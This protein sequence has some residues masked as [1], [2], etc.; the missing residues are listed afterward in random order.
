M[1]VAQQHRQR[2]GAG[3]LA[4]APGRAR[5]R[6]GRSRTR[7]ARRG[8]PARTGRWRRRLR[9]R[10]QARNPIGVLEH[11][12][13]AL[14]QHP[15]PA[16]GRRAWRRAREARC[17]CTRPARPR[18][19]RPRRGRRSS[20]AVCVERGKRG[21]PTG[22]VPARQRALTRDRAPAH[23]DRRWGIRPR[24]RLVRLSRSP[25]RAEKRRRARTLVAFALAGLLGAFF[26]PAGRGFASRG[27]SDLRFA[28]EPSRR[29]A[30]RGPRA[31]RRRRG[32]AGGDAAA[33]G[34]RAPSADRGLRRVAAAA[35]PG[36]G[37]ALARGAPSS[38]SGGIPSRRWRRTSRAC[39]ATRT[40][41]SETRWARA[42][43][44]ERAA[45]EL[46]REPGS[47]AA[48][49]DRALL[50]AQRRRGRRHALLSRCLGALSARTGGARGDPAPRGARARRSGA[51]CATPPRSSAAATPSSAPTATR[52]RSPPTTA[53][54]PRTRSRPRSAAARSAS[55]P[56]RSS[57]CA[58]I[59]EAAEAF[60]ALPQ[61]DEARIARARCSRA[62]ATCRA[63]RATLETIGRESRGEQAAR[64]SLLA[65][66]LLDGEGEPERARELFDAV[67][68][69]AGAGSWADEALWQLGWNAYRGGRFERGHGAL[70]A[71]RGAHPGSDRRAA[72]ALLARARRAAR[73]LAGHD[74][75][76]AALARSYPLTYYG[77]RA[78]ARSRA[79]RGRSERG[80]VPAGTRGALARGARAARILL[81]ADLREHALAELDR[82]F[83]ARAAS[84]IG[85]R[86]PSSTAMPATSIGPSA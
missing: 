51:R 55:A 38:A 25:S 84:T 73:G 10:D 34:R 71:A 67:V 33:R 69:T 77:W 9:G 31:R 1:R 49:R 72:P 61:D 70:R 2:I 28:A 24:R 43:V 32:E 13:A 40:P 85:W 12:L 59:R 15:E 58:A 16:S 23:S 42:A 83:P 7:R 37:Q 65:G 78:S 27:R 60:A 6:R 3:R 64:A 30:A 45:R 36:G 20:L 54:S 41:S 11:A 14:G 18:R 52:R 19:G 86:S 80:V 68:R 47:R 62:R 35:H 53:R 26:A 74:A 44:G 22:G 76:L 46:E 17:C 63:P 50:R 79:T 82:L 66:L 48:A 56:R 29:R 39:S 5:R 81:E 8:R 21:K 4:R 57:A 75:E